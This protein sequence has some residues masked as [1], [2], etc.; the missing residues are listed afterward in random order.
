M[1]QIKQP[2]FSVRPTDD[3]VGAAEDV[4]I[5]A[6]VHQGAVSTVDARGL[7]AVQSTHVRVHAD[8]LRGT[9]REHLAATLHLLDVAISVVL[10]LGGAD[11]LEGR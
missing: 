7:E 9:L 6:L 4:I 5:F 2:H 10:Y 8:T 3:W 11:G 1:P